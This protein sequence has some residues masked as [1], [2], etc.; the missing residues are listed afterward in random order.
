EPTQPEQPA[1]TGA[2]PTPPTPPEQPAPIGASPV[3]PPAPRGP[4]VDPDW[5]DSVRRPERLRPDPGI[6]EDLVR[7]LIEGVERI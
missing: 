3:S 1:T 6:S 4:Q 5:G 2:S 7:R